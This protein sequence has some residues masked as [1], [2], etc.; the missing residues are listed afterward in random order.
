MKMSQILVATATALL[1]TTAFAQDEPYGYRCDNCPTAWENLEIEG[2]N[3]GGPT[4]S[5]IAF[6][7]GDSKGGGK[8]SGVR[9]NYGPEFVDPEQTQTNFEW[10]SEDS[11]YTLVLGRETY[12]FQQFHFHTTA[13]HVVNGERSDLEMHF[14]HKTADGSKSAV[15]ALFIQEG[16][17]NPAFAPLTGELPGVDDAF[18]NLRALLPRSLSAYAYTGSTTT[19]PCSADVEWRLLKKPVTLS[20]A[21]IDALQNEIRIV[22][23]GFDNNRPIQNR[24]GRRI[25]MARHGGSDEDDDD[26]GD[27]DD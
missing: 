7:K 12:F 20:E 2:N 27:D 6:S 17:F 5:P 16:R 19:P 24:E 25:L 3:C 21:Q 10:G 4:Q 18:L 1:F 26:D 8:R 22:N 9:V 23:D 11:V 14:V 13:E 15:L